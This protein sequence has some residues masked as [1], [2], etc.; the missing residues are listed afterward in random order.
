MRLISICLFALL[1]CTMLAAQTCDSIFLHNGQSAAIRLQRETLTELFFTYCADALGANLNSIARNQVNRIS[2]NGVSKSVSDAPPVPETKK[3][4]ELP[5]TQPIIHPPALLQKKDT[6]EAFNGPR[7]KYPMLWT[8]AGRNGWG[9]AQISETF[10]LKN[11]W[12]LAARNYS[13]RKIEIQYKLSGGTA[14]AALDDQQFYYTQQYWLLG[15]N[16]HYSPPFA[17]KIL[18]FDTELGIGRVVSAQDK[19]AYSVSGWSIGQDIETYRCAY[20]RLSCAVLP[21]RWAGMNIALLG[22]YDK[23]APGAG[24][25]FNIMFGGIKN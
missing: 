15:V 22:I 6:L 9:G 17:P 24:L 19:I 3:P 10:V 11:N 20:F 13:Y 7:K 2:H 8:E 25:E 12:G 16:W 5:A 1:H 18:R 14:I 4:A 21:V 23:A